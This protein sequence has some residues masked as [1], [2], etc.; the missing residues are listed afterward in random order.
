MSP[1]RVG[2]IGPG[3]VSTDRH[4]PSFQQ[5]PNVEVAAVYDRHP[6]RAA[7]V[8]ACF[9]VARVASSLDDLLSM[10][11]DAVAIGT[12]PWSHAELAIQAMDQGHHV[13]CEKPMAMSIAEA[14][15]MAAAAERKDRTLTI[16]HNFTFSRAGRKAERFFG[17]SP[18]S[19]ASAVQFSSSQRRLP[20]WYRDLPAGLLFDE[21]PHLLYTLLRWC[22][23]LR[24]AAA[25]ATW[26]ESGEPAVVEVLFAGAVP[27]RATMVF[28]APVSEW[29]VTLVGGRGVVDLDL[30]RDIA[31]RI[32][33]DGPHGARDILRTSASLVTDHVVGFASSGLLLARHQLRWGHDALIRS[34]VGACRGVAPNPVPLDEAVGVVRLTGDIL[35]SIGVGVP[36]SR[37]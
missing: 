2:I 13:F 9:G 11:L 22:G 8:S 24:V 35:D 36:A 6:E 12:P 25:T 26:Q 21:A 7:Q 5:I 1:F 37:A 31:V 32:G 20:I 17:G 23:P 27:A 14:E 33:P 34:F 30:F 18:L 3:W 4:I 10:G 29:H 15:A 28:D 19:Y 16:S